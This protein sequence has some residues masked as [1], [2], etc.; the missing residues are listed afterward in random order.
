MFTGV[1]GS[2]A[3]NAPVPVTCNVAVR[4]LTGDKAVADFGSLG[5]LAISTPLVLDAD[6]VSLDFLAASTP[7][8][9]IVS[10]PADNF[11]SG[12]P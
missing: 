11:R 1:K 7:L 8:L 6:F 9:Q 4:M 3:A 2:L 5:F 12:C 10:S